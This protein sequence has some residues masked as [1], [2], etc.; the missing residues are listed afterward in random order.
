[1]ENYFGARA[2]TLNMHEI[3]NVNLNSWNGS[4]EALTF[5]DFSNTLIYDEY[6]QDNIVLELSRT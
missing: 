4:D 6:K 1:M 3:N 5:T 2:G